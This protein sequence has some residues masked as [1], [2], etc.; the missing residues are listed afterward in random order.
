LKLKKRARFFVNQPRKEIEFY[1]KTQN[2][3]KKRKKV[4]AVIRA[5]QLF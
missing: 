1:P 2:M 3:P 4:A 5:K